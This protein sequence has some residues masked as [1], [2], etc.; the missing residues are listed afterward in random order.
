MAYGAYMPQE[1]SLGKTIVWV[2][3]LDTLVALMAGVVIFAIVFSN[4]LEPS[5][6]PGLMFQT[7]P[8]AFGNMVGGSFFGTVFFILV[9]IAAWSSAISIA[10]PAVA[11]AVEKGFSRVQA[12]L[13]ICSFAW[14]IGIG[15]VLSFNEW[16]DYKL[17]D[18]TFFDTLD[19]LTSN[20]MLPLGGLLIALFVG[21]FASQ[22]MVK[23]E[24][25]MQNTTVFNVWHFILR[26][27]SPTAVV[28]IFLHGLGLL[29]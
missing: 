2:G 16:A 4:N 23:K 3:L 5:A 27:I 14:F 6:G 12:T 13:A 11:W 29:N 17:F 26:Y 19:F 10:E 7:L 1:Q 20:I 9:S 24:A 21:W 18:K 25:N 22:N 8:V 15:S 28:I